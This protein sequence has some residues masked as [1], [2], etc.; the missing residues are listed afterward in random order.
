MN[1][2]DPTFEKRRLLLIRALGAAAFGTLGTELGAQGIF[3]N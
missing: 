1:L 3:G 2:L